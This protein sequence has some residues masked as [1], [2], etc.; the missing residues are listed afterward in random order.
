MTLLTACGGAPERAAEEKVP[1]GTIVLTPAQVQSAGIQADT[2]RLEVVSLPLTVPATLET[3]EPLSA[4]V[5]SI[6]EGRVDEVLVLPG[7]KVPRGRT[8]HAHPLA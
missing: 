2:V 3:P 1:S 7:D 4:R 8:A 5:G 6:V